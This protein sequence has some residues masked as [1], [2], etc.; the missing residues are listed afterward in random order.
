MVTRHFFLTAAVLAVVA[1][2][3]TGGLKIVAKQAEGAAPSQ[4]ARGGQATVVTP[5]TAAS[6]PFVDRIEALGQAKARQSVTI[7]S[8]T[9]DLITAVRFASG[10]AVR[11]GDVLV[12]LNARAQEADV[13]QAKATADLAEAEWNRWRTLADRGVAPKATAEQYEAA[14]Q[15]ARAA[16]QAQ[17]ARRGDRVIRAPF[18]GVVGLSDAAPGMLVNPGAKI[19]TLD[20]VSLIRV[21]F[22]VPERF[23]SKVVADAPIEARVDAL[24]GEVFAGRI[25]T[26]DTRLDATTR[27]ITARAEFDNSSGRL[28]PGMLVRVTLAQGAREQVAAP[29]AAVVF[30]GDDAA[31]YVIEPSGGAMQVQRRLVVAGA[32]E[33]GYIEILEGLEA[34][35][36]IVA[37]GVNRVRPGETVRLAGAAARRSGSGAA[38]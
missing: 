16:Y 6:R 7:T 25:A 21:D 27:A 15:R 3:V 24:D 4:G 13:L 35:E 37:D 10:Q 8:N 33:G 14:Y 11:Q 28:K 9:T 29:E 2:A 5:H 12:E 18:A 22:Q 1:M 31:V 34:G 23:V 32:R 17:A 36:R 30:E 26:V 38:P 20:D 19:V